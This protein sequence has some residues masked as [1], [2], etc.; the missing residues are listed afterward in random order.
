MKKT[1]YITQNLR[2]WNT[3]MEITSN[4][5]SKC[6]INVVGVDSIG[7]L[8]VFDDLA[9]LQSNY[10]EDARYMIMEIEESNDTE[11]KKI[12]KKKKNVV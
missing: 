6:L 7:F 1:I 3:A 10:G 4:V 8:E 5:Y 9:K 2:N 12:R 11:K